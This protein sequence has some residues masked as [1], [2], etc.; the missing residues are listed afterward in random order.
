M[1]LQAGNVTAAGSAQ[2]VAPES[3]LRVLDR[4]RNGQTMMIDGPS[5]RLD[6]LGPALAAAADFT[7]LVVTAGVTR[8]RDIVDFQRATDFPVGKVRGVVLAGAP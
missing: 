7:V 4:A 3:V 1:V 6:P 5:E 2:P 8:A